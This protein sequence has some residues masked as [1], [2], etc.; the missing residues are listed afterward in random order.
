MI[1]SIINIYELIDLHEQHQDISL[2]ALV[3]KHHEILSAMIS[4]HPNM[5]EEWYSQ[6]CLKRIDNLVKAK[7]D[8]SLYDNKIEG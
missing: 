1:E 5:P 3:H 2:C 7:Y 4:N 8:F 6:Q